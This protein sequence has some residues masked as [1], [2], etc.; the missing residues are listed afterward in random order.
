[1]SEEMKQFE[2]MVKN[3]Q[4]MILTLNS[5][6]DIKS[7]LEKELMKSATIPGSPYAGYQF[8]DL[9]QDLTESVL[10]SQIALL[11]AALEAYSIAVNGRR[12]MSSSCIVQHAP[13]FTLKVDAN[14]QEF[15]V[16]EIT[17]DIRDKHIHSLTEPYNTIK[18]VLEPLDILNQSLVVEDYPTKRVVHFLAK[19]QTAAQY[20]EQ[21]LQESI[22]NRTFSV[23]ST[24]VVRHSMKYIDL[25]EDELLKCVAEHD[26]LRIP[27][28]GFRKAKMDQANHI[29][30][31]YV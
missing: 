15:H 9:R 11:Q 6:D 28:G 27:T 13:Y 21:K 3:S 19:D 20:Y 24:E 7:D 1:M 25:L 4:L 31:E 8:K 22:K 5:F 26:K 17:K 10:T 18:T 29:P 30:I 16:A 14:S 2:R 12:D 23:V